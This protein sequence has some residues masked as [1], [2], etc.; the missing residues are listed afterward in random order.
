MASLT[1]DNPDSGTQELLI[2][3]A[4][5]S[6]D[7][8]LEVSGSTSISPHG[9]VTLDQDSTGLASGNGFNR[10]QL[11]MNGPAT[12]AGTIFARSEGTV[13]NHT[14]SIGAG[15]LANTG[16]SHVQS[17][18]LNLR[19]VV[20]SGTILVDAGAQLYDD[21][22]NQNTGVTQND[23]TVTNN[24]DIYLYGTGWVQN[25]GAITGNPVRIFT[26]ALADSGGTGSF[27]AT[28][29][30]NK[31]SGTIPT[32]QTVQFG[33]PANEES[34][35]MNIQSGGLTVAAGGTLVLAPPPAN[36]AEVLDNPVT[37]N[38]TMQV[39]AANV[40]R[41][42]ITTG[43]TVGAGGLVDVQPTGVLELGASNTN[44][45]TVSIAPGSAVRLT[46]SDADTFTNGAD[47]T[48]NFQ[49]ASASSFGSITRTG[50]A[51]LS[52]GG[53][54]TGQLIGDFAPA[55]GEAFKVVNAPFSSGTFA[56]VGTGFTAQYAPDKSSVSL[57][58]SGTATPPK[59]KVKCVVPKLKGKALKAAKRA[60]KEAECK[61]GKVRRPKGRK[62]RRAATVV[63]AQTREPGRN[64]ARAPRSASGS[65]SR[66]TRS[67]ERS[68]R[69]GRQAS[70]P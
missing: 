63:V 20:N 31:I 15:V 45:G 22:G 27:V 55:T 64:S 40:Y 51:T 35:F 65:A 61:L 42:R 67:A 4:K 38:G 68:G 41:A 60:L 46:G 12:N 48:L 25:G 24:G 29:N 7:G 2:K 19:K 69:Y 62:A 28:G 57:V 43:L 32:G 16:T 52:L 50:L 5:D 17:G 11:N 8:R 66:S 9:Q 36:G 49:I 30:G 59:K 23:G 53:T 44:H 3:T 21:V 14:L 34:N 18:V 56:T 70:K 1:L 47:G 39:R 10:P 33:D 13:D 58:R 6:G 26:G 37:V 54:A